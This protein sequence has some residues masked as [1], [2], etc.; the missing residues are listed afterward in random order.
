MMSADAFQDDIV[1]CAKYAQ[2]VLLMHGQTTRDIND[3]E[4]GLIKLD[5]AILYQS[6]PNDR[7]QRRHIN[8]QRSDVVANY[9]FR[10]F[11][12]ERAKLALHGHESGLELF[13][14]FDDFD[15]EFCRDSFEWLRRELRIGNSGAHG[16]GQ[17]QSGG[18]SKH[19]FPQVF[20]TVANHPKS[21]PLSSPTTVQT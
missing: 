7:P 3:A 12:I 1:E 13:W 14:I 20:L 21:A 6:L 17:Q 19:H 15:A 11:G 8:D 2:A 10:L 4:V 9:A 18:K 5:V 16:N